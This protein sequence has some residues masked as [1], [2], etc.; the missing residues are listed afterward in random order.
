M[1]V[2]VYYRTMG[3]LHQFI[4]SDVNDVN[5]ALALVA[6]ELEYDIFAKKPFLACIQGGK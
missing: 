6:T 5:E 1:E 2:S 4:V 3:K